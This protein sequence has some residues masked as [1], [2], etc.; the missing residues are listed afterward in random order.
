VQQNRRIQPGDYLN[1]FVDANALFVY[2]TGPGAFCG[3]NFAGPVKTTAMNEL[4][5]RHALRNLLKVFYVIVLLMILINLA[6]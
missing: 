6:E 5:S 1:R 3:K 4:L 2:K